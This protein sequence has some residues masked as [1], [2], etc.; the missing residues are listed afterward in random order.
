VVAGARGDPRG[1]NPLLDG[2]DD[3]TV[4]TEEALLDGAEDTL[5]VPAIHTVLMIHPTV[6]RATLAYLR[7]GR[8]RPEG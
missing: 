7:T 3:F 6:V 2:D 5:L 8:F 1:Y 4:R